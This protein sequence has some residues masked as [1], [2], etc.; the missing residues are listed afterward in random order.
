MLLAIDVGNTNIVLGCMDAGS[1]R[2]TARLATSQARTED[3]YALMLANIL[4]LRGVQPRQIQGAVVS[5]VVP[6][7]RTVFSRA[8][9][10]LC[11][12]TPLIV[13]AGVKSGLDIKIDNPAQLGSDLVVG[14]VAALA[15]YQRPLLV[16]DFGTA[17]TLSVL[18]GRGRY[19]GGLIIPGLRLAVEALSSGAAQLPHVDLSAPD[20]IIGTNTVDCMNAG[21]I[22]GTAAML[23]GIIQRVEEELG[24]EIRTV[25]GTGGLVGK[26]APYCR[27]SIVV[28][29][30]L[31]LW[32]L[33]IIYHKNRG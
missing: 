25:V 17:T 14:A 3:E 18:D 20:H 21:A 26:V 13:G 23:D 1:I 19:R 32:G 16:F 28:D 2:F 5:S 9:R 27:H 6:G 22:Y 11:G 7:L 8:V 31:M 4:A 15:R 30:E 24:E 33:Q 10:L 12:I 29:D